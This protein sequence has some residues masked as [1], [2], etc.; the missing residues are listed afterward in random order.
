[1]PPPLHNVPLCVD[2]R[3]LGGN[4]TGVGSYARALASA[5]SEISTRALVLHD[6]SSL[7]EASGAGERFGRWVRASLPFAATASLAAP[8][9]SPAPDG[10]RTL[11][12]T[13]LFRLAQV[14]FDVQRRL[15]TV[16][17]PGIRGIMHWTYPVP[18]RLEGWTNL[19]T[20]H[21]A[22]PLLHADLT[23]I[24][25]RRHARLLRQVAGSAELLV[26]VSNA[27]RD[28]IAAVLQCSP[29]R[30][31]NCGIAVEAGRLA[32][33]PPADL[34][35]R[36]YLLVCGSVEARKNVAAILA[37]H[38]ASGTSLPLVIAGP[39]S[40]LGSK[41]EAKIRAMGALR[42]KALNRA[43]M[44]ALIGH[45]RA[46]L[47]PS[48]AEGFGLPVAEAMTLGTPSVI[49]T[50]PALLETAAGAALV[51]DPRDVAALAEAINSVSTDDRLYAQLAK[52]GKDAASRFS[53]ERFRDRLSALYQRF[54]PQTDA[55]A[56]G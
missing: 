46:L 53:P 52:R 47:M 45:A 40:A 1:M 55:H 34:A 4:G 11:F 28:E 20:I 44:E 56:A 30:I 37:A 23:A 32:S 6:R 49:S 41:L 39:E 29:E 10:A 19:Y 38:R 8:S 13:D 54:G 36:G 42:L 27:A 16:R 21:D 2:G 18:L 51:V 31:V 35:S 25:G 7:G 26:T 50:V 33:E 24:D 48:L 3:M 14:Y 9:K 17:T 15:L 43:E 12:G 5:Q 22:I